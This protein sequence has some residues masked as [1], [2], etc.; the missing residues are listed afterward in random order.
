MIPFLNK[1]SLSKLFCWLRS[2]FQKT[3]YNAS[4]FFVVLAYLGA[5]EITADIKQLLMLLRRCFNGPELLVG[6]K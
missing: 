4:K 2:G 6:T 3:V 5:F 1:T